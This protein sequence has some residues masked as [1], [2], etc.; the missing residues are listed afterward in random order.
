MANLRTDYKD[1]VLDTSV[2]TQRKYRMITNE[3]GTV[4]FEDRTV[5]LQTGDAFGAGDINNTNE[6][7]GNVAFFYAD[8]NFYAQ[9]GDDESTKKSLGEIEK[10]KLMEA[11]TY[12]GLGLTLES[13]PE[14]IYAALAAY[15]PEFTY[16]CRAEDTCPELT[17][18]Y[19]GYNYY[20]SGLATSG[21]APT[22][23]L[24]DTLDGVVTASDGNA[25]T[26]AI[27]TEKAIDLTDYT[28][29]IVDYSYEIEN[30]VASN[31]VALHL[32]TSKGNAFNATTYFKHTGSVDPIG[33]SNEA[34]ID[35]SSLNGSYFVCFALRTSGTDKS[36]SIS[37]NSIYLK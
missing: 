29:L 4:S 9:Y 5:Y 22:I 13:T 21:L 28:Q 20:P 11:L 32:P 17:G 35:I 3:D 12:S 1:D 30:A 2:N 31:Y 33:N 6:H 36:T 23:T 27:F 15:F 37:I 26:G 25:K 7:L 18:G 34:I 10:A 24:G 16:L 19:S 8:G 14:E